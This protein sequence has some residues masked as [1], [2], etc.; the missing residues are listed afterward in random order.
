M[1]LRAVV[2][3]VDGTLA[4]TEEIHRQSFNQAFAE[5]G[6]DW[7]WG[8]GIYRDLLRTTGGRERI[9]VFARSVEQEVDAA[10]I[11][12]RKTLIYNEKIGQGLVRLR[13]GVEELI[14]LAEGKGLLLAIGT[15]TSLPNVLSLLD[16][17][18]GPG[19]E[20]LFASIRTGEDVAAKKP[21]P[22]V[23]RLVLDDLG[24]AGASCLCIEDSRNGLEAARATGMRTVITPSLFSGHEDF[25]GA[26]LIL[27]NLA[28]PWS[29]LEFRPLTSL[30]DQPLEV[31]RLL[32]GLGVASVETA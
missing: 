6:L 4:E 20:T 9:E 7:A 11:H 30:I 26:D 18:L 24:L 12:K 19:S 2:F 13:P 17:A 32:T 23:Y 28:L 10:A 8:R 3:D 16:A 27:R 25:T 31:L 22:E 14:R 15:T 1:I 21:D 5:H 29:S